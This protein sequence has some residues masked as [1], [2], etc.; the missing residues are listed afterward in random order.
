[1]THAEAGWQP[2]TAGGPRTRSAAVP[3]AQPDRANGPVTG[4]SPAAP[5]TPPGYPPGGPAQGQIRPGSSVEESQLPDLRLYERLI[6]DGIAAADARGSAVDHVTA[7]RL[8]ICLAAR[9]Q[10]P[11]FAQSLVRFVHTGAVSQALKTQLRIHARSGTYS[12]QPQAARLMEYCIARGTELGPVGENFGAACDQ[13]DRA[14]VM[15]AGLHASARHNHRAAEQAWPE[16]DGPRITALA[17][18]DPDT[19][20]VTLVLDATTASIAMFA[21]AAHA[22]E[23]EAHVREVERLGASLPEGSYGRRN[24]QAIAA[25]ETR[26][27]ARLR[28]VEQAYRTTIERDTA[29]RPPEPARASRVAEHTADRDIEL[30]LE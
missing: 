18:H 22:D 11:V 8:A 5:A 7:R 23:R 10:S 12:D 28:A 21:L 4:P 1:M 2:G 16:K 15:L 14:D 30:E 29:F 20:T 24:R 26:V 19:Q 27:A 6:G 9:P 3:A 17:R 25:R 13:I